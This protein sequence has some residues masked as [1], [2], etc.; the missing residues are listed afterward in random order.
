MLGVGQLR[1]ASAPL[2]ARSWTSYP[3]SGSIA[4][5]I[6]G[7][8]KNTPLCSTSLSLFQL[9]PVMLTKTLLCCTAQNNS[10][11][12]SLAFTPVDVYVG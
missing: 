6:T 2:I 8:A 5:A 10:T 11:G 9:S 7:D 3:V 4:K 12:N 1:R